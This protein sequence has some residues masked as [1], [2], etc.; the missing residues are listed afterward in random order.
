MKRIAFIILAA[1]LLSGCEDF[2]NFEPLDKKTSSNYPANEVEALQ[3]MAGIYTTMNNEH[4]LADQSY[5][6]AQ[7]IAGDEILGGG[8]VNDTKAQAYEAF[9]YSDL[10]ML[11]PNWSTTY[12]GIHRANF[13]IEKLPAMDASA[14]SASVRDQYLG[15]AYFLRAFLYYRLATLYGSVP[16]KITTEVADLPGATP[17]AIFAQ[18]ASDLKTAI[19]IMPAVPYHNVEMGHATRWAAQAM[20]ARAWLFYTGFY[21]KDALPLVDGGSVSK[22]QV[23]NWLLECYNDSEHSLVGDFHELWPY[24]NS[25]TIG[26]YDYIQDYMAETGKELLYAAD[27]GA[28][29]PETVFALQFNTSAGWDIDRG[30]SNTYQLFFAL[31][32]LQNP[33]NTFPFAGGWGQGNSIPK[34]FV[35][36]WE[37]AEP[38][39]PRIGASV[40]DLAAEVPGYATGQWDFVLESNYWGKKYN[41]IT[42]KDGNGNAVN[43]YSVLMYGNQDNN[44]LSHTD[45]LIFIRFADVLLML[46]ELTEDAKY[47][48]EVRDRADLPPV[49]Y[50]LENLQNERK[51]EFAFEGLRFND[52]R[53]W[54]PAYAKAALES[55]VGTPVLNFGEPAVYNGLN[56]DG[57]SARYDE[58]KGFFPIPQAQINL[59]KGLLEQVPGY[60]GDDL[61]PG[62]SN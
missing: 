4:R 26:D 23:I 59:S 15:E 33:N 21:E 55:Q 16:L 5:H 44:Q 35:D 42:A 13:A 29:N 38:G 53:R 6:F 10:D 20:M 36:A 62:F 47:M 49:A 3:M 25:L 28:R 2:M 22:Q 9:M 58:T 60:E 52:M 50:T 32:G 14:I 40:I 61:Y 34:Q 57:Y 24:T 7:M 56:P 17:D 31:R 41:G 39:D 45:D 46:S 30:F 51:H 48:N 12:M 54:G 1:L 11:G 18:I 19:E 27:N 37:A 8:G 43:D